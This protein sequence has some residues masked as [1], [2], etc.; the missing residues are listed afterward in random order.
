MITRF[1]QSLVILLIPLLFLITSCATQNAQV[2]E[3]NSLTNG[4]QVAQ[5][6]QDTGRA[7][8]QSG[9]INKTDFAKIVNLG[10]ALRKQLDAASQDLVNNN[11]TAANVII[12]QVT[13]LGLN[14]MTYLTPTGTIDLSKL[15]NTIT[16]STVILPSTNLNLT[17]STK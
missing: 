12:N 6:I 10:I 11:F 8:Y 17:N 16:N 9:K 7:L 13:T 5:L 1:K 3:Y 14:I 2:T 15:P 4:Y